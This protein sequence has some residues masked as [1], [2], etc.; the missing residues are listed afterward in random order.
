MSQDPAL[1]EHATAM[2]RAGVVVAC[3]ILA[4]FART[5]AYPLQ[6]TWDDARF[7]TDNPLVQRISWDNL[8]AIWS[9]PHFQAYHP[10]HLLAYWLDVPWAGDNPFVL[11]TTNLLL[12]VL[13][14]E[15][16]LRAAHRFGL[17]PWAAALATLLVTLHPVQLEAV[18][19]ATGRKDV[20]AMLFCAACWLCYL[21]AERAFDRHAVGALVFFLL[22]VL[23]KTT[24]LPFGILLLL[25]DTGRRPLRTR[26]ALLWPLWLVAAL[27]APAVL[28]IWRD[29][30]MVR[31][32]AGGVS[33]APRRVIAT[34]GHQLSTALWPAH[35]APMYDDRVLRAPTALHIALTLLLVGLAALGMWRRQRA[36]LI[37]AA[38]FLCMLLPVSNLVPMY[39]P[40]QDRYLSLPLLPLALALALFF[41]QLAMRPDAR[42]A[43][44]SALLLPLSLRTVQ[45]GEAWHSE[46]RLWGH[47]A[48]TQPQ[49]FY[50]WMKL[51]EVR[52]KAGDLDGAIRAY[53]ELRYVDPARKLGYAALL[54]AVALR[55][56]QRRGLSPSQAERFAQAFYRDIGNAPA[57]HRLS[58]RMLQA[59]Y[60]RAAELPLGWALRIDPLPDD[61]LER[62]ARAQFTDGQASLGLFYLERMRTPTRDPALRAAARAA[63]PHVTALPLFSR[64]R[65]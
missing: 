16:L 44:A 30:D 22:A 34:I 41:D 64:P 20:L 3:A 42:I 55:D 8:I 59:G 50:A 40:L 19:W 38:G 2:R 61:V 14:G 47:A 32:T 49:A 5:L 10:L 31:Q 21:R 9:G 58:A 7:V 36:A 12:W 52:R 37:G 18:A 60:V 53:A 48:R 35:T 63:R 46:T 13:S 65:P 62:T 6:A 23:S 17:S 26:M 51:G 1:D 25:L 45:Y 11:H 54:H 39:F 28:S 24:S 43:I 56:E 15:L 27:V 33:E 29:N 4:A 57:L